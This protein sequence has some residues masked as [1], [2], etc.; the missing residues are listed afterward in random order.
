MFV[1]YNV[2]VPMERIPFTNWVIISITC[3]VSFV[4]FGSEET[5]AHLMLDP[6]R[7]S[8]T[9]LISYQLVH[10]DFW[11]LLGN[12][13]FLFC[14]GNAVNAKLGHVLYPVLYF[15]VGVLAGLEWLL[16]GSDMP[17]VGASGAIMGVVGVFVVFFPRNNVQI[18]Y[19]FGMAGGGS[20]EIP[21][22]FVV[23]FYVVCDLFGALLDRHGNIGYSAHI[24]GAVVGFT[25]GLLLIGFQLVESTSYEENLL[26]MFGLQPKT[27]RRRKS[28]KVDGVKRRRK[29]KPVDEI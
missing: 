7:F 17:V 20:W 29:R 22:M 28:V 14:F 10:S 13:I 25:V 23:A 16:L 9:Q 19:F 4:A 24:L 21:S 1:P 2:D 8:A 3:F 5:F 15:G 6:T 11:H 12:M 18:L 27:E 26:Q